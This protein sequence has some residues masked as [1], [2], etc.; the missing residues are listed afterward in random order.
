MQLQADLLGRPVAV[1]AASEAS[2]VGAALLAVRALGLAGDV[3][4]TA[5]PTVVE[6]RLPEDQRR[7][8]RAAWADAVR[9][10]RGHAVPSPAVPAPTT[11]R[12]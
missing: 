2:A 6:P 7:R 3:P 1:A 10:S 12:R 9:R 8:A 11:D 4:P 5:A